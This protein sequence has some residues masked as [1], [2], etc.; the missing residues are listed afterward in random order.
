M[1]SEGKGR[2]ISVGNIRSSSSKF[3]TC[4]ARRGVVR[5][6]VRAVVWEV[7]CAVQCG[8]GGVAGTHVSR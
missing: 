8:G 3:C 2:P 5:A 4:A 6:V 1:K 7:V